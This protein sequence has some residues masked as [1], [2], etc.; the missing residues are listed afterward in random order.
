MLIMIFKWWYGPG[1]A[2]A[3][4]NIKTH[5]LGVSRSF[6]IPILLRTLFEPWRRVITYPGRTLEDHIRSYIDNV[7][8]RLVGF[9]V[10]LTVLFSAGLL[11]VITALTYCLLAIVWPLVPLLIIFCI[12][13][14]VK[15]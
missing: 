5:T 12:Y 9:I 13:M 14:G 15:G 1:W 2:Q 4:R 11:T 8:S 3:F 6:S 10:R 7:V